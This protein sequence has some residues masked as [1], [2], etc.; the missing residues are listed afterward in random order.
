MIVGAGSAGEKI[1]R[2]TLVS[3]KL[4]KKV[5]CF[6]DDDATKHNRRI[7][8][9]PIAGGRNEILTQVEKYKGGADNFLDTLGANPKTLPIFHRALISQ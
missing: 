9:V 2:E 5:V 6:I 4:H 7:H 1:L 8:N 3:T